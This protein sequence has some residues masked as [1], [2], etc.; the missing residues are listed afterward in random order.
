MRNRF[1][2]LALMA[3]IAWT[4]ASTAEPA[5]LDKSL[6]GGP[7]RTGLSLTLFGL[8]EDVRVPLAAGAIV[9]RTVDTAKLMTGSPAGKSYRASASLED[10]GDGGMLFG[11][12]W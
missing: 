3:M 2:L 11:N 7:V 6:A 12:C 8:R 1:R 10:Q 9:T 5:R 4:A